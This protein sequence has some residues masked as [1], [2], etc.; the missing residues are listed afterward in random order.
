MRCATMRPSLMLLTSYGF[1]V[2]LVI[3]VLND[4]VLK[5]AVGGWVTG[6]LSD[7]AGLFVFPLFWTAV[8]PQ[9]RFL[10]HCATAAVFVWWKLPI[11]EPFIDLWNASPMFPVGRT[12]DATD[13]V[14]LSAVAGA[15]WFSTVP[16]SQIPWPSLR[17]AAI[18]VA[19]FSFAATS[20]WSVQ[21]YERTY[22]FRAR[23]TEVRESLHRLGIL[24]RVSADSMPPSPPSVDGSGE[25]KVRLPTASGFA[26]YANLYLNADSV[27]TAITL[28]ELQYGLMPDRQ[29]SVLMISLFEQCL[30]QRL[31][32]LLTDGR[33]MRPSAVIY[34]PQSRKRA[35]WCIR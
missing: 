12:V 10:I 27:G 19:L 25:L 3:L 4:L 7:F 21:R 35:E 24:D 33:S 15:Y 5:W 9:H 13:L 23:P 28:R 30:V 20:F 17:W 22:S 14:A 26:V 31:D 18:P 16:R 8:F 1:L 29:D 6:K 2:A 11:S 32:S 34:P